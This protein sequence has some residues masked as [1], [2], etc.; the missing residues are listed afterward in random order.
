MTPSPQKRDRSHG[1]HHRLRR[2]R[3]SHQAAI[4]ADHVPVAVP[5]HP[6]IPTNHPALLTDQAEL[7]ELLDHVREVGLC[8]YDTEFIG[9]LTYYPRLCLIQ[10]AT[11][12][13]VAV[14]DALVDID[15]T[16]VWELLADP[17]VLKLVHAG[18]QDLEPVV[19]HLD[20]APA[21]IFDTQVA[22]GFAR[23]PYPLSLTRLVEATLGIRLGKGLTF[24]SW[25]ER[26]L[27]RAH[28]RYA[29]DDVRYL[30]AV[31]ADLKRRVEAL[32]HMPLVELECRGAC[33]PDLYQFD[34]RAVSLRMRG[35]KGL[36]PK[37]LSVLMELVKV[38]DE[39]A[40]V[41][42]IPPRA[43]LRDEVLI[44]MSRRHVTEI[45]KLQSVRGLPRPV[46]QEFGERLIDAIERG[47]SVPKSDRPVVQDFEETA[48]ERFAIDALW[49]TVQSYC[50]AQGIDPAVVGT[51]QDIGEFWRWRHGGPEPSRH[52]LTSGWR[53]ELVGNFIEQFTGG[54]KSLSLSWQ[55]GE[56]RED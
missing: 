47:L 10:I 22:A 53:R 17:D 13:R 6:L 54:E 32:G 30:P 8:A 34:P 26:P 36:S 42:N 52:R 50:L 14:I 45:E 33:D 15:L 29:A 9:E 37:Q 3:A 55:G 18:S 25:D 16:G 12:Q 11:P 24:T 39:A 28:L 21:N 44:D 49:T 46:V 23:L 51:R 20:R 27:S 7:A 4:A 48:A 56:L 5:D 38:R 31:H 40:Q 41:A 19:R 2:R 43:F 1:G 35:A